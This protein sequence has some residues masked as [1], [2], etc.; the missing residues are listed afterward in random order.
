MGQEEPLTS[1]KH[2]FLLWLLLSRQRKISGIQVG[3]PPPLKQ[4]LNG[5]RIEKPAYV[6][7]SSKCELH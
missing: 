2:F 4:R 6:N 1:H 3:P 5:G 7:H